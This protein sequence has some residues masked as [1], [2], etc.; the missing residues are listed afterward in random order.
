MIDTR[1]KLL[2]LGLGNTL[3]TD[4][5]VGVHAMRVLQDELGHRD[6]LAFLDGG[7]LSFTLAAPIADCAAL[8]VID[9]AAL[10]APPGAVA[11]FEGEAMDRFIATGP[12]TSVHEVS[13]GEVLGMTLAQDAL[14]A[15][16]ALIGVRPESFAW[17]DAP[18]PAVAAAIPVACALARA[19]I[20]E[21]TQ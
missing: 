14:P 13:L 11:A 5:G 4:E 2:V 19:R 10:D 17:G 18:S 16:R 20:E 3:L 7:T 8:V 1:G 9:T 6:D 21:W 12:K 15:R